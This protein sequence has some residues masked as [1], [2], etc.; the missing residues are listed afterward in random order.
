MRPATCRAAGVTSLVVAPTILHVAPHPDDEAVGCPGAL[1]HLRDRGWTVVSVIAS[2]GFSGQWER[3]G[4]GGAGFVPVFL[5]PPLNLDLD[6]DLGG[7]TQ[8]V[9]AE[10]PG[11]VEK[12]D[13]S[14]VVS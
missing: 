8:R 9:A 13:A 10:L 2:L 4:A 11:I 12:H 14:I 3:R 5:A 1:L 6:G 7:A